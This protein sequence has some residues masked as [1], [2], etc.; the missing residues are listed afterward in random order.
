MSTPGRRMTVY[1]SQGR[2]VLDPDWVSLDA[3]V[4]VELDD[5][6][7]VTA[8]E[9]MYGMG[10]P[11]DCSRHELEDRLD[12]LIYRE[13]PPGPGDP[14]PEAD[15]LIRAL[16]ARGADATREILAAFPGESR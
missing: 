1:D 11:L 6:T 4:S 10:G 2:P 14:G 16:R 9:P 5:G 7:R 8:P 13:P 12:N 3:D 15:Q